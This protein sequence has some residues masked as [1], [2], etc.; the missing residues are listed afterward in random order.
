MTI[1]VRPYSF[2]KFDLLGLSRATLSIDCPSCD[3]VS[4]HACRNLDG[5]LLLHISRAKKIRSGIKI[6]VNDRGE[7]DWK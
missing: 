6:F 5:T 2:G 4:G 1:I 3:A 7:L